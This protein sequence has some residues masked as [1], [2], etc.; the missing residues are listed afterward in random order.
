MD[1]NEAATVS[2]LASVE[3]RSPSERQKWGLTHGDDLVRDESMQLPPL[4]LNHH[5]RETMRKLLLTTAAAIMLAGPA[6]A[7]TTSLSATISGTVKTNSQG[8]STIVPGLGAFVGVDFIA[9]G[10]RVDVYVPNGTAI[11]A[12]CTVTVPLGTIIDMLF[13]TLPGTAFLTVQGGGPFAVTIDYTAGCPPTVG[14]AFS[15]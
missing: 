9:I 5:G 7:K 1:Q 10:N 14:A 15:L 3:T 4:H 13:G 2:G 11:I 6:L 12:G 8:Q